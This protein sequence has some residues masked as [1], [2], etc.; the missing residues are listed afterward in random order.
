MKKFAI[1]GLVCLVLFSILYL[2]P[3][4]I[5]LDVRYF[6]YVASELGEN[7]P[8]SLTGGHTF[9]SFTESAKS[10]AY[11]AT[12]PLRWAFYMLKQI[13]TFFTLLFGNV[14]VIA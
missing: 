14:E 2:I 7:E 5:D 3:K 10:V 12:I 1:V 13:I 6:A 9:G 8:P 11:I 4:N